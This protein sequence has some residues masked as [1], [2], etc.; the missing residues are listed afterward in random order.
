MKKPS[1]FDLWNWLNKPEWPPRPL[2]TVLSPSPNWATKPEQEWTIDDWRQFATFLFIEGHEMKRLL[3]RTRRERDEYRAK[4][5][6]R[7]RD[8]APKWFASQ[9]P[10]HVLG[11]HSA[12]PINKGRKRNPPDFS[13]VNEIDTILA[14]NPSCKSDAAALNIYLKRDPRR[15]EYA[16]SRALPGLKTK[17]S[18]AR[19]V[20]KLRKGQVR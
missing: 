14:E 13:F 6:R 1:P 3:V 20:T 8:D 11:A 10:L 4:L 19:S 7:K 12:T 9:G 5:T 18:R 16:R 17:L 2:G 15:S